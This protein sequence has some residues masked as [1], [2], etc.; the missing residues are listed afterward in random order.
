M[1]VAGKELVAESPDEGL[2]RLYS[3]VVSGRSRRTLGT[4]FT[5]PDEVTWMV[6]QWSEQHGAPNA[7][8][9]VG[10]GVG[11]FTTV[12]AKAWPDAQVWAVDINP[13]TLGLLALRVHEEF[14]LKTVSDV[15]G[16][17]LRLVL[18]D[19]TR[20]MGS[21]WKRLPGPRLILGNPPYTRMQLLP[22]DQRE[23]LWKSAEGLCG[24]R[25]S[26]SAL[27]T[28]MSL[29]ALGPDDGLCLLLPA[30]WLESDYAAELRSCLWGLSDRR[31]ELHLFD[32]DVFKGVAQ[33]DAVAL[34]VGPV[35]STPQ[36]IVFS[37]KSGSNLHSE[38]DVQPVQWRPLFQ[39]KKSGASVADASVLLS[40][41][42]T[43]KRGVA[44]G[45]NQFFVLT[46]ARRLELGLTEKMVTPLVRRLLGLPDAVTDEDLAGSAPGERYW[47]LTVTPTQIE[48]SVN[49]AR[50]IATGEADG[51]R[52][53]LRRLCQDRP[54]WFDLTAE[55]E[56]PHV[57][58]GQSTKNAFRFIEV[59]AKATLLNNLY[60]ITWKPGIQ[61]ETK[62][63][64][65]EWLRGDD[66][67]A[68]VKRVAR[69]QGVGL[70]KVEPRALLTVRLPERFAQPPETLL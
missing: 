22:A 1:I 69:S 53:D 14:P 49:L 31:V 2:A 58:V 28:A 30:Q 40:D 56:Y 16:S 27:I 42:V 57:V 11:I 47:L 20:W 32:E 44:T 35:E 4:F 68:A 29:K 59:E 48:R 17:G 24:R 52:F 61:S 54:H 70:W 18:D 21:G 46:E 64:V 3:L 15:H 5:P 9:D 41:L 39:K 55:V 51:V 62:A 43:V 10:A 8:A 66:G 7:V 67:Q 34:M 26:L 63:D 65:L 33:V 60:G 23:R 37:G 45:A 50:Y 38:R 6:E 36:P 13:I 25:A 12:A 19:F